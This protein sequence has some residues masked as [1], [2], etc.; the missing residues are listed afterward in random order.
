VRGTLPRLPSLRRLAL[1]GLIR[2][3]GWQAGCSRDQVAQ[4]GLISACGWQAGI[5]RDPLKRCRWVLGTLPRL[6]SL[7]RLA[8]RCEIANGPVGRVG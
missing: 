5:S 7:R 6:P 1:Q 8:L 2:A 4:Q 3:S